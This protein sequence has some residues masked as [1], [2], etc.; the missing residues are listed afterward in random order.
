M[1]IPWSQ[2]DRDRQTLC[3]VTHTRGLR[4]TPNQNQ[5]TNNSEQ[6][7]APRTEGGLTVPGGGWG[8]HTERT[9]V[10]LNNKKRGEKGLKFLQI[11]SPPSNE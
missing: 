9:A 2:S 3:D 11:H 4:T 6:K 5:R 8:D 7:Q 10:R 1:G